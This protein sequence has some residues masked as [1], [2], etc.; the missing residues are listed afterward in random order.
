MIVRLY[1]PLSIELVATVIAKVQIVI[2]HYKCLAKESDKHPLDCYFSH[3]KATFY[4]CTVA[5]DCEV[6]KCLIFLFYVI[7]FFLFIPHHTSMQ[8]TVF[9]PP[10]AIYRVGILHHLPSNHPSIRK[11]WLIILTT[12]NELIEIVLSY[13]SP[14]RFWLNSFLT[15]QAFA[16]HSFASVY[17]C[18][19][20]KQV[21]YGRRHFFFPCVQNSQMLRLLRS[22]SF[23]SFGHSHF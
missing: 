10:N 18:E 15:S 11:F 17:A 2:D 9:L 21:Y 23:Y 19:G 13:M 3:H 16:K 6:C 20:A 7:E 8:S 4:S 1:R 12:R 22:S 5:N 14:S